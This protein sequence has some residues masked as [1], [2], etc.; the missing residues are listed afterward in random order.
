MPFASKQQM[1]WGHTPEGQKALGGPAAVR[2]WDQSTNQST[3]PD[4]VPQRKPGA[5]LKKKYLPQGATSGF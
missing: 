1:K 3:L 5:L 4:K 2:E